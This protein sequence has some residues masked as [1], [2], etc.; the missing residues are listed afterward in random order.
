VAKTEEYKILVTAETNKAV[1]GVKG[2]ATSFKALG[3]AVVAAGVVKFGKEILDASK[4]MQTYQNQLRLVTKGQADLERLMGRL[5]Q[6]SIQNRTSFAATA[7]LFQKLAVSTSDLGKTEDQLI[8]VTG[9]LSQALAVAGADAGTTNGVIRQFG[10]AMASGVVRGDEFNSIV[11]GLGPA[12]AIMAQETGLNVGELRKMATAGELTAEVMFEMFENSEALSASFNNM[13]ITTQQLETQFSDSYTAMLAALGETTG[14]TSL[15]DSVLQSLIRTMDQLSGRQGAVANLSNEEL[16]SYKDRAAALQEM[17]KRLHAATFQTMAFNMATFKANKVARDAVAAQVAQL[18]QLIEEEKQQAAL[19]KAKTDAYNKEVEQVNK[20]LGANKNLITTY[21]NMD[22]KNFL[23]GLEKLQANYDSSKDA[24][25]R[26]TLSME[27]LNQEG[28]DNT[29]M[30]GSLE[31]ALKNATI[32][33]DA[34]LKKLTEETTKIKE[35]NKEDFFALQQQKKANELTYLSLRAATETDQVLKDRIANLSEYKNTLKNIA[36]AEFDGA[37]TALDATNLRADAE[38]AYTKGYKDL[39]AERVQAAREEELEKMQLFLDAEKKKR[40]E[41]L[42]TRQYQFKQAGMSD[43]VAK[44][45]AENVQ[46]YEEDKTKFLIGQGANFFKAFSQQSKEA[47]EA[48]KAMQIAQALIDTY[49]AATAAYASLAVIP[50]IGPVLGA[51]AAVAA[52]GF[53]MQQVN[54]IKSQQYSGR[55]FGGPVTGGSTYMVGE[56]GPEIFQ[57]SQNGSIVPNHKLGGEAQEVTVNFNIEAVDASGIDE[58]IL[59]RRGMIT[60]IIREATEANGRR[61]MV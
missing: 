60:N 28:L 48:Y 17:E 40:D 5:T 10:Q 57:A 18:K 14:A 51:A 43:D 39:A 8:N 21:K 29:H 55:Q 35:K 7:E 24:V 13:A 59:Q 46:A 41:L 30:Y 19:N 53:G 25:I 47:F 3:A 42:L 49:K 50:V 56:N 23:T 58:L 27:A 44:K 45:A 52:I 26:L 20:L 37:I 33:R 2:L 12:L 6:A 36:Q 61:S 54:A 11:E 4:K 38:A 9:K 31:K 1:N 34:H 22:T 15:Y 32:A 16:M